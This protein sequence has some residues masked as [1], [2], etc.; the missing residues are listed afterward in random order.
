[1]LCEGGL[2][3]LAVVAVV[4]AAPATAFVVVARRRFGVPMAK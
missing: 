3:Y 2:E 4:A 1:M